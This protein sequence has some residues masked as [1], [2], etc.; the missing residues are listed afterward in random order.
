[1]KIRYILT[2]AVSL[3]GLMV[4]GA[5]SYSKFLESSLI[6]AKREERSKFL[7]N[8][9]DI[10]QK[11]LQNY[12]ENHSIIIDAQRSLGLNP[13]RDILNYDPSASEVWPKAIEH[14]KR[15]G[16]WLDV[17]DVYADCLS[18][19]KTSGETLREADER[20]GGI[21]NHRYEAI[22][23]ETEYSFSERDETGKRLITSAEQK[24]LMDYYRIH[25]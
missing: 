18:I 13:S 20:C 6:N 25:H 14:G 11:V 16:A 2:I 1:M 24:T 10:R 19:I 12:R 22:K 21:K 5:I 17:L 8:V 4:I 3:T 7:S 9:A 15:L 23:P